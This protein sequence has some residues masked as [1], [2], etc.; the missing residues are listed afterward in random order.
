MD[1][2]EAVVFDL[3]GVLIDWS[4]QY[5][6]E[7]LI[8]DAER[9]AFFLAEIC[10]PE[11]NERLD[12]GVPFD[13]AI[14]SLQKDHPE[15]HDEIA[16]YGAR[17]PEMMGDAIAGTVKILEELT[18]KDAPLFALTNWSSETFEYPR[19]KFNFL[20]WFKGIVVSGDER[21]AKPEIE[22]FTRLL[23]RYQLEPTTTLFIDDQERN[24][25]AARLAGMQA[26]TFI[27]PD[28]LRSYLIERGLLTP[29]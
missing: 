18:L 24:V 19:K 20:D 27:S 29:S 23:H 1:S 16:A 14:R 11:W 15:W 7:K 13:K 22:I 10:S 25:Q 26:V 3:G 28:H 12:R 8:P 17:W 6:Y 4:P 2:V 5:L 21:L 9:R